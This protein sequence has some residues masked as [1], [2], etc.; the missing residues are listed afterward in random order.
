M[1]FAKLRTLGRPAAEPAL[2]PPGTRLTG[3]LR[4]RSEGYVPKKVRVRTSI[5]SHMFTAEFLS[6]D[7]S[8]LRNDPQV[9]DVSLSE[10]IP[11]QRLP[12][13]ATER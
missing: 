7:L 3:I 8:E 12:K 6:E 13:Q 5:G 11:L 2:P 10:R 1:D 9:E 4:V